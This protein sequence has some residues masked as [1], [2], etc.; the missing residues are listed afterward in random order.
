MLTPFHTSQL[1]QGKS[2]GFLLGS[3]YKVLER[4]GQG[5][6]GAVFLCEHVVMRRLVAVKILPVNQANSA[7]ALDRFHREARAVAQ[8]DHPNIVRAHDVDQDGKLHFLVMEF[9]DGNTL[10]RIVRKAG[11]L[12]L[13]RACHY[14]RQA[15]E[16]LQ[17]A[18][19]AGLVH[20][21]VK[22]ANLLLGRDGVLKILDMGLARFFLD[23]E[24]NLTRDHDAH[25][26]LGTADYMAPEQAINSTGADIRA[27]LYSLGVTFYFLLAGET[28]FA[29]K[30]T[31]QKL[32]MHQFLTP[33]RIRE[34]CG[35]V[36]QE[37]DDLVAGL[38]EKD[39]AH[40]PQTPAEVAAALVP[41]TETPIP[42]PDDSEMPTWPPAIR[43][44]LRNDSPSG[45]RLG[46]PRSGDE[47]SSRT[48]N[49]AT[50]KSGSRTRGWSGLD[51]RDNGSAPG[52]SRTAAEAE[53]PAPTEPTLAEPSRP[54][55]EA[56]LAPPSP[57]IQSASRI[58]KTG[59]NRPR[60]PAA[61]REAG[62]RPASAEPTTLEKVAEP[63]EDG[64]R[65]SPKVKLAGGSKMPLILILS[66]A[67]LLLLVGLGVGLAWLWSQSSAPGQQVVVN[68]GPGQGKDPGKGDP[69][70]QVRPNP[71]V[72]VELPEI[73]PLQQLAGHEKEV[74]A[75]CF[76]PDGKWLLSASRD[77]T[78]RLWEVA[79][80]KDLRQFAGHHGTVYGVAVLPDGQRALTCSADKSIRLWNLVT[81]E[82]MKQFA[83]H[84]DRVYSVACKPDGDHFLSASKDGTVRLWDIGTAEKP[85]K[86]LKR[87]EGHQGAV[88]GVDVSHDGRF[89]VSGGDDQ[90]ARLWDIDTGKEI[91]KIKTPGPVHR[92]KFAN[93][94]KQVVLACGPEVLCWNLETKKTRS[95]DPPTD[96]V[97]AATF[98]ANGKHVLGGGEDGLIRLWETTSGKQRQ[99]LRGHLGQV[100]DVAVSPD[101]RHVASG[102]ADRIILLWQLPPSA[103]G[104]YVGETRLLAGHT[105]AIEQVVFLPDGRHVISSSLDKT[106]GR[107]DVTT[108]KLIRQFKGHTGKLRGLIALPDGQRAITASGDKTARLWDLETGKEIRKFEGHKASVEWVSCSADGKRL[109]TASMDGTVKLWD[110]D[111]GGPPLKSWQ[112]YTDRAL[113]VAFVPG[114]K[115]F[116]TGGTEKPQPGMKEGAKV[117]KLWNL[118]EDQPLSQKIQGGTVWR[119]DVSPDGR[120]AATIDGKN[121][122]LWDLATDEVRKIEVKDTTGIGAAVFNP[123]GRFLLAGAY[124]GTVRLIRTANGE[125]LLRLG[126]HQDAQGKTQQTL[127]INFSPNGR[128]AVSGGR[129]KMVR[130]WQLP[131]YTAT[132]AE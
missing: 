90:T 100:L 72:P 8:L 92:V 77:H 3:K 78:L 39:P 124:D 29:G 80:G 20:R 61:L 46:K 102:G 59:R 25:S 86:E 9:V 31:H 14:V 23:S 85:G 84:A 98:T 1:L 38:L 2:R 42:P 32:M 109:L 127:G 21:D 103:A 114:S 15:A 56:D 4:L 94:G 52:S 57:A 12:P 13:L 65:T 117:I 118:A 30:P 17:H 43:N 70:A 41:W 89:A 125:E 113:T 45:S 106:M 129:D 5:G 128:L 69:G 75:V 49:P 7:S 108:G 104:I 112:A 68:P 101:G 95:L 96:K 71:P 27:D 24:D 54:E 64:D 36:P 10:D 126:K 51:K 11:R 120:L 48:P 34:V 107:W 50:S 115:R 66:G 81:G 93:D 22:P 40:R 83:G 123:D 60:N 82:E 110:V 130:I 131:E 16:G 87:L 58:H 99:L 74:E 63:E 73:K 26:M 116:V 79:T 111:K 18:H 88:F 67:A 6:M 33:T 19:E 35:D 53:T 105:E 119:V 91:A 132:R 122:Q 37:I 121:I 97:S 55:E 44:L 76:T 28:P 47:A 62:A